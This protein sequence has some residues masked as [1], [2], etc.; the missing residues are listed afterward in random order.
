M[1]QWQLQEAK[2]RLS[3]LVRRAVKDGPQSV[4][5]RGQ[6]EVVVISKKTYDQV[7]SSSL[8]FVDFMQKSPLFG[9]D[10]DI[11]RDSSSLRDVDL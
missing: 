11:R 8:S 2:A 3:E 5:V 6:E 4:T 9:V 10:L 7:F 1:D